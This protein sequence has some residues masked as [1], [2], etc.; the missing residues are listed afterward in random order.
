MLQPAHADTVLADAGELIL[1]REFAAPPERV[2]A[3]WTDRAKLMQWWGPEG[4]TCPFCELDARAGGRWRTCMRMP[5]GSENWASGVYLEFVPGRR[6]VFTLA[7]ENQGVR[8]H[9]MIVAVDFAAGG[10]GT[11]MRLHQSRFATADSCAAHRRGWVSSFVC[12][13]HYIAAQ[14]RP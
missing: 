12:L 14:R 8:G 3:A 5:D 10:R 13:E 7:W 9:E 6:L 2:F 4:V 1:E 11:R